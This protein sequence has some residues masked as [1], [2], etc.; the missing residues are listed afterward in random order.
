M[1]SVAECEPVF[2]SGKYDESYP[3][4][5][6]QRFLVSSSPA[7]STSLNANPPAPNSASLSAVARPIPEAAPLTAMTFP[8]RSLHA[9]VNGSLACKSQGASANSQRFTPEWLHYLRNYRAQFDHAQVLLKTNALAIDLFAR[10]F[11]RGAEAELRPN[12]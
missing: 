5:V 2:S 10:R 6:P 9:M 8:S 12:S 11:L 1:I 3:G 4:W 7:T